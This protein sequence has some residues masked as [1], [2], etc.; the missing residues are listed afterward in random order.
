MKVLSTSGR[1]EAAESELF[2]GSTAELFEKRHLKEIMMNVEAKEPET[3][4]K[5]SSSTDELKAAVESECGKFEE[6]SEAEVTSYSIGAKNS[7][8]QSDHVSNG[9]LDIVTNGDSGA[10]PEKCHEVVSNGN[11]SENSSELNLQDKHPGVTCLFEY[12]CY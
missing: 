9:A 6:N 4:D 10:T 11:S 8:Q 2:G 12:Y 7:P 3:E 5:I 1:P